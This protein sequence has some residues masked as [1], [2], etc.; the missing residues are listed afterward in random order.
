MVV[1][2]R[3]DELLSEGWKD[4]ERWDGCTCVSFAIPNTARVD[5]QSG[6]Q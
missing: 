4:E 3:T 5:L 6:M 1:A 2:P